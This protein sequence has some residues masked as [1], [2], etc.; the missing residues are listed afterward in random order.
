M[1]EAN[2]NIVLIDSEKCIGCGS[3][4]RD[5]VGE[6]LY[7]DGG[8][9]RAK[10]DSCPECGHCY[11]VC[12]NE[13]F[14]FIGYDTSETLCPIKLSDLD[15]EILLTGIKSRRSCRQYRNEPIPDDVVKMIVE[16]GRYAPT[17]SNK[18]DVHFS[19]LKEKKDEIEKT[20]VE[21]L[22][23]KKAQGA[24]G[25]TFMIRTIT[26]SFLFKGAPL[27]ILLSS[28]N[29]LDAGIASG[30]MELMANSLGL[31]VLYSGYFQYVFANCPELREMIELPEE[32]SLVSCMVFG[33]PD[34]EY[35]RI[36]PRYEAN[37]TLL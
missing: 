11:A 35:R 29:P 17:A 8:V 23:A 19:I 30:Y 27:V 24:N 14:S 10:T 3:C 6:H 4:V 16:A 12:P 9:V 20:A 5:C 7:L 21:F 1:R 33:Y 36:V 25:Q 28:V 31:G 18:Q 2:K 15:P 13:V 34:V 26:D 22:R 37:V 32:E